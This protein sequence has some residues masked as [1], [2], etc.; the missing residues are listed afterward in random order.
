MAGKSPLNVEDFVRPGCIQIAVNRE[1]SR[2]KTGTVA[3]D[4]KD[5]K[6]PPTA[7]DAAVGPLALEDT[8]RMSTSSSV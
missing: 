1:W 2:R 3:K 4:K 5:T 8:C 7:D 6:F